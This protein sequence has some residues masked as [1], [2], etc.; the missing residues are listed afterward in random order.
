M[1]LVDRVNRQRSLTAI[2][3][4]LRSGRIA[5][6]ASVPTTTYTYDANGNVTQAGGWS[7]VWDYL[8]RML[9]SGSNNSTTTYG[10]DTAGA[11]VLQ[12]STTSTSYYPSIRR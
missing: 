11:R 7:Y 1:T 12:T 10:Y 9:A 3:R 5:A 4:T 8:N 6:N 2:S